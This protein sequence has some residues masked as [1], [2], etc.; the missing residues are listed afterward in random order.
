MTTTANVPCRSR[1]FEP[2]ANV[3]MQLD[4]S[5]TTRQ[6]GIGGGATSVNHE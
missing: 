4:R 3:E 6:L 2:K 1:H 5:K